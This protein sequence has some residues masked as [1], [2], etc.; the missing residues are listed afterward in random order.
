MF[1]DATIFIK[2]MLADKNNFTLET[3][4]SGYVLEK[5][6]RGYTAYTTSLVKDEILIW[7]SRYK[8]SKIMNFIFSLRALTNLKIVNPTLEDE[9]FAAENFGKYPLGISDLINLGVMKRLNIKE[10]VSSDR[11]FD[12]VPEVK[13]VFEELKNEKGFKEFSERM[14]NLNY[15]LNYSI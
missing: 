4:L 8:T 11:G 6:N 5:I 1:I 2:W 3:A 7:L 15:K 13:R 12:T 14:R 9:E 10:V